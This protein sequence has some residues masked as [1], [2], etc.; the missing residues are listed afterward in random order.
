[1]QE[2]LWDS[3]KMYSNNTPNK[4][5]YPKYLFY[6]GLLISW[7]RPTYKPNRCT[8]TESLL[9]NHLTLFADITYF[10]FRYSVYIQYLIFRYLSESNYPSPSNNVKA[11][12]LLSMART[13]S[14]NLT[15]PMKSWLKIMHFEQTLIGL[16]QVSPNLYL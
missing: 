4:K 2:W 11:W 7:Q 14:R 9:I 3:Q 8:L 1:M 16:A 12:Y 15:E 5:W 13:T 10:H 6:F